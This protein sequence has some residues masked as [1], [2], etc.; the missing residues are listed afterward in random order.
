MNYGGQSRA[1]SAEIHAALISDLSLI[2]MWISSV[3]TPL[4]KVSICSKPSKT[5]RCDSDTI[6]KPF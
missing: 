1:S 3:G 6:L 2:C 5:I 4:T